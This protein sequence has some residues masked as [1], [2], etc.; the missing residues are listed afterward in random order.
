VST[1]TAPAPVTG[2]TGDSDLTHSYC[3]CA[4]ETALCG[5]VLTL[6]DYEMTEDDTLCVVCTDLE[7]LPC[8]RCG[9]P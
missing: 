7:P 4:P 6:I 5:A 8:E 3:E 2:D 9:A 1:E